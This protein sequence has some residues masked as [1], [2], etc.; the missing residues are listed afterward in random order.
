MFGCCC[1]TSCFT[2]SPHQVSSQ[3]CLSSVS[4]SWLVPTSHARGAHLH[5]SGF[6]NLMYIRHSFTDFLCLGSL[7]IFPRCVDCFSSHSLFGQESLYNMTYHHSGMIGC[8]VQCC[9]ERQFPKNVC[10]LSFV[11]LSLSQDNIITILQLNF[12]AIEFILDFVL[13]SLISTTFSIIII[14]SWQGEKILS[15]LLTLDY[16]ERWFEQFGCGCEVCFD[17]LDIVTLAI[18][19]WI[20][21]MLYCT[22]LAPIHLQPRLSGSQGLE[23][24][25][26]GADDKSKGWWSSMTDP[27]L[28]EQIVE[29]VITIVVMPRID[30]LLHLSTSF[31]YYWWATNQEITNAETIT[32]GNCKH[33]EWTWRLCWDNILERKTF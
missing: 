7:D 22:H 3:L 32:I 24:D 14:L 5:L 13:Y 28:T 10:S 9:A 19:C 33:Q 26:Q 8:S 2:F 30:N 15:I 25:Q 31:T 27:G 11:S 1:V 6:N 20:I 17:V 23:M 29:G 12:Q 18:N 4:P 21:I 16:I